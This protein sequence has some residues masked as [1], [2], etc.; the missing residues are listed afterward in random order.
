MDIE[1]DLTLAQKYLPILDEIYKTA[2]VTS[3]MDALTK[4][5]NVADASTVLIYKLSTIGLGNYS[6]SKGYPK[7]TVTGKWETLKLTQERGREF[8]IDRMDDE[9]SLGQA[10]GLLADEFMRLHVV[11]EVDAYRFSVY[12][13]KANNGRSGSLDKSN[14]L[15]ALAAA[16]AALN[17]D[18]VPVDGRLLF[19]SDS[20]LAA[21]QNALAR[22][23]SNESGVDRRVGTFDGMPVIMVPQGRFNT[24]IE[25]DPGDVID[26]GGFEATGVDIN[27]MIIHPTAVLQATKHDNLKVFNPD[28]NQ[29]ADAYKIQYRLY[30]DAFVYENKEDGIYV[31]TVTGSGQSS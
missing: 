25:L 10:F 1:N 3:R 19:I 17:A 12:A 4:P 27:F 24:V 7:G 26:E 5:V 16:E 22:T 8:A 13:T 23:W 30:H 9:E 11:P 29:D 31:H 28:V 21:L 14:I 6:R 2:S 20:C 18:E 15:E